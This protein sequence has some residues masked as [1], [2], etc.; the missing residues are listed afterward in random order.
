M[1]HLLEHIN[2]HIKR[3]Q[4]EPGLC[5]CPEF[6]VGIWRKYR[7]EPWF[8]VWDRRKHHVEPWF[9]RFGVWRKDQAEPW[10]GR[11]GVWIKSSSFLRTPNPGRLAG[12]RKDTAELWSGKFGERTGPNPGS[13]GLEF[14]GRSDPFS[15]FQTLAGWEF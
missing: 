6:R 5:F 13:A 9:S 3:I 12:L 1:H 14:G 10:F 8:G 2:Q 4:D 11:F 7:A 15:K